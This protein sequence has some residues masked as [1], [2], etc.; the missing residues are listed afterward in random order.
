MNPKIGRLKQEV[1]VLA[2]RE[3]MYHK[4]LL[5][6]S[7]AF[8]ALFN[9]CERVTLKWRDL[10]DSGNPAVEKFL[11]A[12]ELIELRAYLEALQDTQYKLAPASE[13]N[14]PQEESDGGDREGGDPTPEAGASPQDSTEAGQR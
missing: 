4:Q 8:G 5:V 1:L 6:L 7:E 11:D 12:V 9:S 3:Q 13:P 2:Q 10:K 14:P